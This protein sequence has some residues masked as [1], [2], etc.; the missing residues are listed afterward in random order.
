M[1]NCYVLQPVGRLED[2]GSILDRVRNISL[3][4][5][6]QT[7]FRTHTACCSMGTGGPYPGDKAERA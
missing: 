7:G 3:L 5:S 1:N 2:W 4:Q 6:V